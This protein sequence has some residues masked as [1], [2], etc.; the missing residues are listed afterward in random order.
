[1]NILFTDVETTGIDEHAN[2]IIEI[3]AKLYVNGKEVTAYDAK[4]SPC[5]KEVDLG[6]L[7]V[8]N[9]KIGDIVAQKLSA[10]IAYNFADWLVELKDK[11]AE[12][13]IYLCGHNVAFDEK[14][15]KAFFRTHSIVGLGSIVS[16]KKL[17]TASLALSLM[18]AGIMPEGKTSLKELAKA[19]N[20][21]MVG[22]TLHRAE[23]DVRLTI[24]VYYAMIKKLKGLNGNTSR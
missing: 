4:P 9:F 13:P 2:S 21:N 15:I 6:A 20:I 18:Q 23:D 19:L 10:E 7:K 3:S 16:H 5:H 17:D 24:D 22:R 1:M 12:G 8:N 14:F 11:K